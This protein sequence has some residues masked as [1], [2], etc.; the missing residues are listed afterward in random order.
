LYFLLIL[1][2]NFFYSIDG[3]ASTEGWTLVQTTVPP[4]KFGFVP[5]DYVQ[6]TI[7]NNNNT[8]S[9]SSSSLDNHLITGTE[10]FIG[11]NNRNNNSTISPSILNTPIN[12]LSSTYNNNNNNFGSSTATFGNAS[13]MTASSSAAAEEFGQLFAS[14][15]EWFK[16][17]TNKRKEI[18]N[19]LLNEATDIS[20]AL[21]EAESKSLNVLNRVHELEKVIQDEK[22]RWQQKLAEDNALTA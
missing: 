15:E 8:A 3:G 14:H 2:Y 1:Y 17:A 6:S 16:A 20:R 13:T 19:Q 10:S 22:T 11:S 5:S 12:P 4:I 18:Y 7:E 21:Q 9:S